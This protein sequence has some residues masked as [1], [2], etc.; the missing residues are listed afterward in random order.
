MP[1]LHFFYSDAELKRTTRRRKKLEE[2]DLSPFRSAFSWRRC[3]EE[4][5]SLPIKPK[6][7][8][9]QSVFHF[10]TSQIFTSGHFK[11]KS[12][13]KRYNF[14]YKNI[15]PLTDT[16]PPP[17]LPAPTTVGSTVPTIISRTKTLLIKIHLAGVS[18]SL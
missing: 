2:A 9:L 17:T 3:R 4:S 13:G 5:S 15:S 10:S 7:S 6:R 14:L 16:L 12:W 1:Y 11:Q 18:G 8:F